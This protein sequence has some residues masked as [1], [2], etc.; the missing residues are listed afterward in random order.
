MFSDELKKIIIKSIF[1]HIRKVDRRKHFLDHKSSVRRIYVRWAQ[2]EISCEW[3]F[4]CEWG[5]QPWTADLPV[6]STQCVQ[7]TTQRSSVSM[8]EH[9]TVTHLTWTV[10]LNGKE[11]R[12]QRKPAY[13][14]Q[15]AHPLPCL[16]WQ[17]PWGPV[18]Q[19]VAL[20]LETGCPCHMGMDSR[21]AREKKQTHQTILAGSEHIACTMSRCWE[22]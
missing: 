21:I 7:S 8:F 10:V 22:L 1:S 9:T 4:L 13:Q 2:K 16:K 11:W 17:W 18:W 19:Y 5:F 12:C 6:V 20:F 15:R 3:G 14:H